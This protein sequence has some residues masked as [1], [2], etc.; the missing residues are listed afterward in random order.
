MESP[1]IKEILEI[2]QKTILD[3]V[4]RIIKNQSLVDDIVQDANIKIYNYLNEKESPQSLKAWI[5]TISKNTAYDHLRKVKRDQT[6]LE[7]ANTSFKHSNSVNSAQTPEKEL[8]TQEMITDFKAEFDTL[9]AETKKIF[10]LRHQGY[11]Y[12]EIAEKTSI[13][14]GKVK[15]KIFR[16]RKKLMEN[17]SEKGVL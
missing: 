5:K 9:D 15:T 7:K 16:G 17:L 12:Q 4:K 2:H 10:V 6:L 8:L 11:S 14:L 13:S 1:G 3:T